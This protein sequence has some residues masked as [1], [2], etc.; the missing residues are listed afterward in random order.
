MKVKELIK[1]LSKIK[2]KERKI[3]ILIGD[4]ER[5][6]EGCEVFTLMRTDDGCDRDEPI[7]IFMYTKDVY[8]VDDVFQNIVH[9]FTKKARL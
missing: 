2:D 7:E 5:D 3:Q 8:K 4:E 6:Y 1:E 9:T